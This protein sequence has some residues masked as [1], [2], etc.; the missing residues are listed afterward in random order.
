LKRPE[1]NHADAAR[2]IAKICAAVLREPLRVDQVRY[3]AISEPYQIRPHRHR[4]LMQFDLIRGCAGSAMVG[5]HAAEF[6]R[7]AAIFVRPGVMHGYVLRPVDSTAGV[8]NLRLRASGLRLARSCPIAPIQVAVVWAGQIEASLRRAFHTRADQ[9]G[10]VHL[11]HLVSALARWPG[12]EGLDERAH[13]VGDTLIE[14]SLQRVDQQLERPLDVAG[15]AATSGLSV[16][17]FTRRFRTATGQPPSA[18]VASR[19]LALAEQ[20]L[21]DESQPVSRVASTLGFASLASFDRWF[22]LRRGE[23]PSEHRVRSHVM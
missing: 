12:V 3:H 9:R 20:L 16:R 6:E 10:L 18:Y 19:R 1:H 14:Q 21:A 2:T 15:M 4:D 13:A 11:A 5:A 8:V 17:Q 7:E 22:R 23:S